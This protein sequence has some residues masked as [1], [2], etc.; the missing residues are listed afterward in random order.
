MGAKYLVVHLGTFE[1]RQRGLENAVQIL[2]RLLPEAERIGAALCVEDFTCVHWP[3]ALGDRP[4]DFAFLF[5]KL[6]SEWIGLALDYGHA[7]I[8]GYLE[9]YL[10]RFGR[11]L[12]YTHIDDND[13]VHDGHIG[14]GFGTVDWPHAFQST[15]AT[16]FRGPFTIEYP[17]RFAAECHHAVKRWLGLRNA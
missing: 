11:R 15:L 1:K 14:V 13:G 5:D 10:K 12:C 17:E 6:D 9:E 8:T 7:N 3:N 2:E 16:G 4:E